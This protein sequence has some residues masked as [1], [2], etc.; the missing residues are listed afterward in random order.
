MSQTLVVSPYADY[1]FYTDVYLGDAIEEEDFA[2]LELRA[3]EKLDMMTFHR[4]KNMDESLMTE[5]LAIAIK[6]SVCAM[7]E[8]VQGMKGEPSQIGSS[9][10]ISAENID[11]Y[12]VSYSSTSASQKLTDYSDVLKGVAMQYLGDSGLLYRGGGDWHDR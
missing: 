8:A 11:G 9:A 1:E 6:K 12:S 4:I 7:A 3:E 5:D 10:G 2:K